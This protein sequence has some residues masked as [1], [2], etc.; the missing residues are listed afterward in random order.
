MIGDSIRLVLT[1]L[2]VFLFVAAFVL[3]V[4]LKRP[5]HFPTRL[6]N[7]LLLLSVGGEESWAGF[8]HVFF[9]QTA[10]ATIGWQVSP[11][12][13]EIGVAD[14]AVGIA[15]IVSFWRSI[16]FKA[17]IIVYTVLFYIGVAIG[18]VHQAISMGDMSVNNFGPLLLITVV[19][20]FLLPALYVIV[21]RTSFGRLQI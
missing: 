1:N 16:E 20:V 10:A 4:L 7:F 6:L 13:F 19:K 15:A 5:A 17:A 8:F 21:R 12:Q 9:P 18:H 14:L 2:P 11:F 3:A